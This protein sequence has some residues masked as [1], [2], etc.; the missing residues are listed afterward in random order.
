MTSKLVAFL[1][2]IALILALRLPN[3]ILT[4]ATSTTVTTMTTIIALRSCLLLPSPLLLRCFGHSA[5]FKFGSVTAGITLTKATTMTLTLVQEATATTM[6]KFV[7]RLETFCNLSLGY[8]LHE[9]CTQ[10]LECSL[11]VPP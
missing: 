2:E 4:I 9:P 5:A 7:L 11:V 3:V 6:R 1:Q 8:K 10:V